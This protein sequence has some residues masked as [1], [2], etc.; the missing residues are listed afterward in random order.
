MKKFLIVLSAMFIVS[1]IAF[2][3]PPTDQEFII[4][5]G[6]QP[7]SIFS[8]N[9]DDANA[10][11]GAAAGFEYFKYLGN[12]VALGAGATYDL[13][14]NFKDSSY[15]GDVSFMPL[16]IGVKARTPLKGLAA[17]YGFITGR[18]GY[19]AF[20]PNASWIKS[21]SGGLYYA[22]GVGINISCLVIEAVYAVNNFSFKYA[23]DNKTYKETDSTISLYA[24][25]KFE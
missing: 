23:A 3:T 18:I 25:F 21:S 8:F 13:P 6:V 7:Q 5:A 9:G 24:G 4:K 12:V 22:G 2:A 19:S 17:N 10:N 14:R 1:Q 20:I 16:Y 11:V 15:S